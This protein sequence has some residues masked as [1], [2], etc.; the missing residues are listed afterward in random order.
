M[1]SLEIPVET[2]VLFEIIISLK[3]GAEDEPD[4]K[5]VENKLWALLRYESLLFNLN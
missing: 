4:I 3:L 2:D 5:A 1:R